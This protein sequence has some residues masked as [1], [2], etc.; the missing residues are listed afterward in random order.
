MKPSEELL[1][2]ITTKAYYGEK[3]ELCEEVVFLCNLK[4]YIP[5]KIKEEI[6]DVIKE[7]EKINGFKVNERKAVNFCISILKNKIK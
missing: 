2:N 3:G 1:K 5:I 6:E 4:E 7:I